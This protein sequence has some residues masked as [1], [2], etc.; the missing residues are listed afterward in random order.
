MYATARRLETLEGFQSPNIKTRVLDVLSDENVDSVVK[1]IIDAEGRID[2]LVNNA[3][4]ICAGG[5]LSAYGSRR[6]Q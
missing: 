1:T 6:M 4:A 5:S 3:G 2:V